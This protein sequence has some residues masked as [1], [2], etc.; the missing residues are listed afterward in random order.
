MY[1]GCS[2]GANSFIFSFVSQMKFPE[3]W[4]RKSPQPSCQ[5]FSP[6]SSNLFSM[7]DMVSA[8][9]IC[10]FLLHQREYE[11]TT[12]PQ[13]E[14]VSK[15]RSSRRQTA[16]EGRRH[17]KVQLCL[18]LLRSKR[19][20][21]SAAVRLQHKHRSPNTA[22]SRD[23]GENASFPGTTQNAFNRPTTCYFCFPFE[24]KTVIRI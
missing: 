20:Q 2:T 9:S 3:A 21:T 14:T 17:L 8:R 7:T 4:N 13:V 11:M 18:R 16:Q 23:P 22:S 6:S 12:A 19:H 10:C 5:R 15:K 24:L 1:H